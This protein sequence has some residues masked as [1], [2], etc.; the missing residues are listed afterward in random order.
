MLDPRLDYV[1]RPTSPDCDYFSCFA[2]TT[3]VLEEVRMLETGRWLDGG[4]TYTITSDD[5]LF[6]TGSLE[7]QLGTDN[8]RKRR[9]LTSFLTDALNHR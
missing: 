1:Q 4:G 9:R 2:H 8:S 6:A 3:G 5:A 7:T